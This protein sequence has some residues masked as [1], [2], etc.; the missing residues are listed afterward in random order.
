MKI[1]NLYAGSGG[2]RK[3]WQY[4]NVTAIELNPSIAEIYQDNYPND[5]IIIADAHQYLLDHY[6]EFDF[7]WSSPVCK[8]HSRARFWNFRA[9]RIYP[10][11]SLYEEILFL[12]THFKGKY[13]VEM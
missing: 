12:S 8:S 4:D 2:N 5:E 3:S 6:Q 11:L 7:I 9:K 1:L 10:D 13:C